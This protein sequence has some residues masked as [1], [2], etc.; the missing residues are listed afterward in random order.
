MAREW[1]DRGYKN[2]RHSDLGNMGKETS[3]AKSVR[4]RRAVVEDLGVRGENAD[5]RGASHRRTGCR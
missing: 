1:A 5:D 4:G 3:R 2:G